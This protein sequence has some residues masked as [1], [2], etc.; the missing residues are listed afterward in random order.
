MSRLARS[1]A[2]K[3]RLAWVAP[4]ELSLRE[5]VLPSI[6]SEIVPVY[7]GGATFTVILGNRAHITRLVRG[8]RGE[9]VDKVLGRVEIRRFDG[10]VRG[11]HVPL[12][13]H[14]VDVLS[15]DE[16]ELFDEAI[17]KLL[18]SRFVY[19]PPSR[20]RA[21]QRIGDLHPVHFVIQ[22]GNLRLLRIVQRIQRVFD[23]LEL[24]FLLC[25]KWSSV[26]PLPHDGPPMW[27]G[28]T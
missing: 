28:R 10:E 5:V 24:R 16:D 13:D 20:K 11:N 25:R 12:P 18:S 15:E 8:D 27:I 17:W 6:T 21:V 22:H 7:V 4:A 3:S 14:T 9:I 2:S 1:L 26:E 19:W 23:I